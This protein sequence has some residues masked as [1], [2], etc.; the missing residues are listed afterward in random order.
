MGVP[1]LGILAGKESE[2]LTNL[3]P[4]I[5]RMLFRNRSSAWRQKLL[6]ETAFPLRSCRALRPG[7]TFAKDSP[8]EAPHPNPSP[9]VPPQSSPSKTRT[10]SSPHRKCSKHDRMLIKRNERQR[11]RFLFCLI[12]L[13]F[14]PPRS[15]FWRAQ[16]R[17]S[18]TARDSDKPQTTQNSPRDTGQIGNESPEVL[19]SYS[20]VI[21]AGRKR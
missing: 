8:P 12:S 15:C 7:V 2:C 21:A 18:W 11:G 1:K 19:L 9:T 10:F 13:E 17:I 3:M 14:K 20:I 4:Q 5:K 6:S 16:R